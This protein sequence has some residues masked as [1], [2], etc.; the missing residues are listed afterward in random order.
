MK[1]SRKFKICTSILI[2]LVITALAVLNPIQKKLENV[3]KDYTQK[4]NEL[5]YEKAEITVGYESFSPSILAGFKIENIVC[6]DNKQETVVAIKKLKVQY[7]LL[8]AIK[9]D[10]SDIIR[11]ASL[12]GVTVDIGKIVE[13]S[14]AAVKK[15]KEKQVGNV[16]VKE[17]KP[18]VFDF[19]PIYQSIPSVFKISDLYLIYNNKF[20]ESN[21]YVNSLSITNFKRRKSLDLELQGKM[22]LV[23]LNNGL[24]VD[25]NVFIAG[26]ATDTLE[27]STA[28]VIATD[29]DVF[30]YK[31]GKQTILANYKDY[32]VSG[33][34]I[35]TLNPLYIY[36]SY[37][38]KEMYTDFGFKTENF[39]P[40]TVFSAPDK[41]LEDMVK[42]FRLSVNADGEYRIKEKELTFSSD[43]KFYVPERYV[44]KGLNVDYDLFGDLKSLHINYFDVKGPL[45]EASTHLDFIYRGLKLDGELNVLKYNLPN[46]NIISSKIFFD[47]L[48]RG[49]SIFSPK[50][51]IGSKV[52]TGM[53]ASIIPLSDSVDFEFEVTDYSEIEDSEN[54]ETA[55]EKGVITIGGSYLQKSKYLQTNVSLNTLSIKSILEYVQQL[56]PANV[57]SSL[58]G[59]AGFTQPY[60]FSGDVYLSSDLKSVSYNVPYIIVANTQKDNQYLFASLDGNEQNIQLN[61]FDL[62]LGSFASNITGALDI[63]PE[64]KDVF[65]MLDTIASSIPYH[66]NGNFRKNTLELSGDY[67]I[68]CNFDFDK[69]FMMGNFQASNLPINLNKLSLIFSTDTS[70]TYTKEDGPQVV[71]QSMEIEKSDITTSINP[72]LTLSGS[73]TKYGAQLSSITYSDRFSTLDGSADVRV[74]V[75]E[76]IFNTAAINL[77]MVN[78]EAG[79]SILFDITASNPDKLPLS[80]KTLTENVYLN[81]NIDINNFGLSRFTNVKNSNNSLTASVYLTGTVEHPYASVSLD[82]LSVLLGNAFITSK[83]NILLEDRLL[84]VSDF[85]FKYP[86]WGFS[87]FS[88]NVDLSKFDGEFNALFFAGGQ[89]K[90]LEVPLKV[91]VYDS[92]YT[93]DQW[94]PDVFTVTLSVGEISGSMMKQPVSFEI[95]ANYSPDF[96]SIFSSD[97]IG[98]VGTYIPETGE[99]FG[100]IDSDGIVAFDIGGLLSL[101]QMNVD[102]SNIKI[103]FKRIMTYFNFDDLF[104]VENAVVEGNVNVSGN[105]DTPEFL[106]RLDVVSPKISVPLIFK[107]QLSTDKISLILVNNEFT[108]EQSVYSIKNVPKFT[109]DGHIVLNKWSP[110]SIL[111]NLVTLKN[112]S[113]PVNFSNKYSKIAGDIS[114]NLNIIYDHSVWNIGGRVGGENVDVIFDAEKLAA[115]ASSSDSDKKEDKKESSLALVTDLNVTFGTHVM[116]NFKPFLRCILAPNSSVILQIDTD[117]KSYV[118]DGEVKI[119][120]G[121]VSYLQ[122]SFYIKEGKIKFNPDNIANPLITIKAETREKDSKNQQVKIILSAEN[123]YVQNLNPKFT[124][125]PAKSETEIMTLLGQVVLADSESIGEILVSVGEYYI[126]SK[127]MGDIENKLRDLMNF[128]IFSVKTNFLQNTINL[129]TSRNLQK[130]NISIGNFLDN[131]TVYIGKYL[132]SSLYVDAMMNLSF[133]DGNVNDITA[134]GGL[135][136]KPEIGLELELPIAN[137]RWSMAPDINALMNGQYVP[138]TSVSLSWKFSF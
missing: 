77:K 64:T 91:S 52:L 131:T 43:G 128:D 27:N 90:E 121:D 22:H 107:N 126:Q 31:I 25:G 80:V 119:K 23:V 69:D 89:S 109:M 133:E 84:S 49:F 66:I 17:K 124:S 19:Q 94:M 54:K 83:G 123:Q 3:V 1:L 112:Q 41:N 70:F 2:I 63:D 75:I 34:S 79:E 47:N 110:D 118:V 68:S 9:G 87:D 38:F 60:V 62:I 20:I 76:G 13:I 67:G 97:N 86:T 103:D 40:T 8:K 36:G 100:S 78:K 81:S 96:I 122:R 18:Y 32:E 15:N 12:D 28:R 61:R 39:A 129:S 125:I 58:N 29:F 56:V 7:S 127:F 106:G 74:D 99:V 82:K 10:Y 11:S 6:L 135:L 48:N 44:P 93:Q 72:K 33:H 138:S 134:A 108:L 101:K 104:K 115:A 46:G 105:F 71:V 59:V 130:D 16:K 85:S 24:N 95:S 50:V 45:C 21:Y 73:G 132:G 5:L 116:L 4:L 57:A 53:Q 65:F 37:N 137:I 111:F 51:Y 114:C 113:L 117:A 88:G 26:N 42:D 98:L 102:L 92:F 120:S 55:S 136:F 35:Q 30:G 14:I